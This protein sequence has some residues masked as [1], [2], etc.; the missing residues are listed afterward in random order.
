MSLLIHSPTIQPLVYLSFHYPKD[1]VGKDSKRARIQVEAF[2][3]QLLQES[4]ELHGWKANVGFLKTRQLA[5]RGQSSHK[6]SRLFQKYL[7]LT[8]FNR[9]QSISLGSSSV[10]NDNVAA[11]LAPLQNS[12][13]L[14]QWKPHQSILFNSV[15][16]VAPLCDALN[17]RDAIIIPWMS[18]ERW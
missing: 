6:G 13:N 16:I 2:E 11:S 4:K 3:V 5:S 17:I 10:Q 9:D 12:A 15:Q 14:D 8:L 1:L 18:L 7:Y